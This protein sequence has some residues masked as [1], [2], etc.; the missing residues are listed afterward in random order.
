MKSIEEYL[1][2]IHTITLLTTNI[3]TINSVSLK[4]KMKLSISVS[5]FFITINIIQILSKDN[6]KIDKVK[7]EKKL[8]D[9]KVKKIKKVSIIINIII[10]SIFYNKRVVAIRQV[11]K[12]IIIKT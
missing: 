6:N 12:V 9:K 4:I 7:G 3:I 8:I 1:R 11:A 5:L 10:S 2:K